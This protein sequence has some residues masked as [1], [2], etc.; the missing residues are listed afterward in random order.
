[1][2]I[3]ALARENRKFVLSLGGHSHAVVTA[4]VTLGLQP[5]CWV[6]HAMLLA[7]L[8]L[9]PIVAAFCGGVY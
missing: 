7:T 5:Q 4:A 3:I 1:M 2:D 6:G 8:A 9:F